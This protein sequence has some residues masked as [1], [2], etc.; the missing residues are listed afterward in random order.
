M[1][2]KERCIPSCGSQNHILHK[3]PHPE[4]EPDRFRTWLYAV[5][6]D[7][8]SLDNNYI[9]KYRSLCH[10]HFESSYYTWSKRLAHNAIPTPSTSQPMAEVI[11]LI[12]AKHVLRSMKFIS[13]KGN[14][15]TVPSITNWLR[16]VENIELLRDTLFNKNIKS[17][18]ARHLNQD[19]LENFF[20]SI[21]SH[22][23]RNTSPTCAAFEAAFASLLVNNLSRNYSKGSNCED[24]TCQN[25]KCFEDLFFYNNDKNECNSCE[26]DIN[27]ILC[28]NM[29]TCFD[30]KKEDARIFGTLQY[31]AGYILRQCQK[32]LNCAK[33]VKKNS[34]KLIPRAVT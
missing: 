11:N 13:G 25:F 19:P 28:E 3:F 26:V 7:L 8:L 4:K 5:G 2:A 30:E 33:I 29:I 21:R 10:L 32:I 34:L 6:G 20:G 31:V 23:V 16:T 9:H 24:D 14:A 27:D 22:G 15:G 18:W 1:A 17:I 12:E